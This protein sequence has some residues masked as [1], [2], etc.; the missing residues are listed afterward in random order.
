MTKIKFILLALVSV[1]GFSFGAAWLFEVVTGDKYSEPPQFTRPRA[2]IEAACRQH[3][4][5]S[6]QK[7]SLAISHR[8]S[9]FAEFI[10][11]RKAGVPSFAK[12][13]VSLNGKWEAIK[14]YLPFTDD[15]GHKKYIEEQF[16]KHIFS[17][18][19]LGAA[20]KRAVEGAVKD[21]EAIENE[22]AV[23][24]RQEILGRSLT[25]DEAPIASEEFKKAMEHM[26]ATSQWDAAKSAGSLMVSE[27][28]A[29]VGTQVLI[30]LGVSSGLLAS[31]A[32]NS[33]W[34]FG[35]AFFIGLIADLVWEWI[36]DP[37]GDIERAMNG[38]LDELS[39]NASKAINDEMNKVISQRG[40]RWNQVVTGLLQ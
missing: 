33:W 38:N 21:L 28:A 30:R 8:T 13:I 34:S 40:E 14:P 5:E 24:L 27:V 1:F 18:A 10:S 26:V 6:N 4:R 23:T 11:S 32:V 17:A 20:I 3:L 39:S 2:E 35:G 9:E 22:L 37:A 12:E 29:Q 15:E 36:D 16:Q 25:P 19:D 31:G 7:A